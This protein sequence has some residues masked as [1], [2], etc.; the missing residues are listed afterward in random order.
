MSKFLGDTICLISGNYFCS[1]FYKLSAF[2][3]LPWTSTTYI[4]F[5]FF[6]NLVIWAQSACAAKLISCTDSLVRIYFLSSCILTILLL[7]F[8]LL[9]TLPYAQYPVIM[10]PFFSSW[11]HFY[12]RV[13][14]CPFCNIPGVHITTIGLFYS[15]S[16]FYLFLK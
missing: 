2:L 8:K 7:S 10:T 14:D 12:N 13:L 15:C 11:H 4:G 3:L 9:A 1:C 16:I 5:T 6:I